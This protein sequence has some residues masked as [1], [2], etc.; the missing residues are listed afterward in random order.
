M[1]RL[2]EI[3]GF[4]IVG[5]S[6]VHRFLYGCTLNSSRLSYGGTHRPHSF[7]A[8]RLRG[9]PF[10]YG[11][12]LRCSPV[13]VWLAPWRPPSFRLVGF[14]EFPGISMVGPIEAYGFR[15]G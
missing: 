4:R 14:L 7:R 1:D 12:T 9:S 2:L 13:F 15:F 10:L 8:D 5:L 11:W 3:P 6:E